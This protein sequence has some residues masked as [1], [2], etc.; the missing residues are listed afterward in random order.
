[1]DAEKS[2]DSSDF[3]DIEEPDD[4]DLDLFEADLVKADPAPLPDTGVFTTDVLQQYLN[5][6]DRARRASSA[7]CRLPD[8][9]LS[10][11]ANLRLVVYF[12]KKYNGCGLSLPDLIQEGNIGLLRAVEKFDPSRGCKFSTY[13]SYWIKQAINRALAGQG[14]TIRVPEHM[15]TAVRAYKNAEKR[16]ATGTGF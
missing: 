6:I 3:T 15:S 7:N 4:E 12:A 2:Y 5:D 11:E 14:K 9:H 10:A 13:A 1:M 8:E 16:P